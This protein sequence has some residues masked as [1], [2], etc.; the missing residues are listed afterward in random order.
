MSG[1]APVLANSTSATTCSVEKI[2]ASIDKS[3]YKVTF[4]H[5][6]DD[7]NHLTI[8]FK[9]AEID[10]ECRWKIVLSKLDPDKGL[11]A[12]EKNL[13]EEALETRFPVQFCLDAKKFKKTFSDANN[14]S[15]TITIEKLGEHPL[16]FT[17]IK[18]NTLAYHEVYRTPEKIKLL[19][20]IKAGQTFRCT[21]K[22]I[23]VRALAGSM[24][25]EA[26][27]IMCRETEDILF[28]SEIDEKPLVVSVFTKLV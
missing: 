7:E 1:S 6:H 14:Y 21:I 10:K 28:R 24:V 11:Y 16:Q 17:Y 9:D 19:S 15:G 25:T 20:K 26:V 12:I 3:F 23:N 13:T 27:R 5:R 4:T 22:I 8:V 2:F 18:I